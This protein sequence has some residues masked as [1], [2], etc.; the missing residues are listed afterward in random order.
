MELDVLFLGI[1]W[2]G[3]KEEGKKLLEVFGFWSVLMRDW[4]E[5]EVET[6]VWGMMG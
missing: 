1:V 6:M 2:S 4:R 5:K 3:F